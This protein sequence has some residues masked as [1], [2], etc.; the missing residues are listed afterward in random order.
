MFF[1]APSSPVSSHATRLRPSDG[2]K[3]FQTNRDLV[4]RLA[5]CIPRENGDFRMT[6]G[7]AITRIIALHKPT[8][9]R[10]PPWNGKTLWSLISHCR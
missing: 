7:A 8:T 9:L 6:G 3:Y 2:A 1:S 4:T 10:R 5:V